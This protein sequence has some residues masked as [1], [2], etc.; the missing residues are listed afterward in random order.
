M[1]SHISLE[2]TVTSVRR[3]PLIVKVMFDRRLELKY[4]YR[5]CGWY[6]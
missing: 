6:S 1:A 2:I 4:F 5:E 3:V